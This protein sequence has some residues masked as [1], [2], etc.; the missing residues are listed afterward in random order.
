MELIF[1]TGNHGKLM[2]MKDF[3]EELNVDLI[4]LDDLAGVEESPEESGSTPLENA[5][6]KAEY[7]YR[8]FQKPVFSCDSGFYIH[9]LPEEEQ[10][11][12]HVRN[13]GG[14]RLSDEEMTAYYSGIAHRLGG[15]CL[16]EYRNAI[17]LIMN[18]RERYE[19]EGADI[20]GGSFY[21]VDRAKEQKEEGF[22][23]DC[24]SVDIV[25]G[26]YFVVC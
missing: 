11:G 14:R 16:A 8:I 23:L 3:L 22:P 20:G 25:T 4:G 13:V 21:L 18:S 2:M 26:N 9:G 15:K 7:Y 19:Y 12:V 5:R 1:G 17:C 24:I 6:M 10:P